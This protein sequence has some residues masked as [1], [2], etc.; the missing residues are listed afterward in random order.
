MI[1]LLSFVL[2]VSALAGILIASDSVMTHSRIDEEDRKKIWAEID[3]DRRKG[4]PKTVI[5][6]LK[7]IQASA[8]ADEDWSEA[9]LALC[10][11]LLTEGQ[12]NQPVY[13]YVIKA[14]DAE[15]ETVPDPMK[16]LLSAM[17]A[18]YIF[19]YYSQN[20]WRFQKRSQTASAPG[21]D[22]E[23]WDLA[24]ILNEV[25]KRFTAALDKSDDLKKISV[26]DYED[27]LE[28]GT[29][30]DKFRPT[31]YDFIAF[32]AIAFYSMDEQF[33]RQ[34]GA[35]KVTAD[36]PIFSTTKEFLNW[37]PDTSDDDS[38][39]LRA[40]QLLQDVIQYHSSDD[41]KSALLDAELM[42]FQFGKSVAQGSE[43][44]VR[45]RAA[46]QRFADEHVDQPISTVAIASL[47]Q[48]VMSGEQDNVKAREIAQ[49]L[50][51]IHI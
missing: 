51:L 3:A 1:R 39:V 17:Q 5:A 34:Q 6:K 8:I 41:D 22:I 19:Q 36:S 45:Y 37:K 24:R 43:S 29:V 13:I 12:I 4:L 40:V 21:D 31:L 10:T 38:Y 46:L 20:R 49:Q 27:L 18:E 42:R 16:P 11:R 30:D 26:K 23:A 35:F 9:T 47:A 7:T 48:S 2:L 44:D 28:A 32:R 50:S 15:I 33:I 25:D 14:I